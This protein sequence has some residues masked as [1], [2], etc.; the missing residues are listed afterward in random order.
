[1]ESEPTGPARGRILERRGRGERAAAAGL[2]VFAFVAKLIDDA[3]AAE[4]R[5]AARAKKRA[6]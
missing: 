5:A 6:G 3:R 4:A 1:M 2:D